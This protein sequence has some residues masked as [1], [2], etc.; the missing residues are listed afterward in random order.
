M[1][2]PVILT[3]IA[4]VDLEKQQRAVDSWIH[5]GFEVRSLNRASE[6]DVLHEAFPAVRFHQAE[7]DAGAVF[8]KPLVYL[9]DLFEVAR[10]EQL[11]VFGIV[12]SDIVFRDKL[13]IREA[14]IDEASRRLVFGSRIDVEHFEQKWGELYW[15]GFDYFFMGQDD[16]ALYPKSDFAIGAPYWDYWVP[17]MPILRNRVP[18]LATDAMAL[19][20]K[21]EQ[22]WDEYQM[23]VT[24]KEIVDLSGIEFE[25]VDHVDMTTDNR[26]ARSFRH[27]FGLFMIEFI[28]RN[29]EKRSLQNVEPSWFRDRDRWLRP[30]HIEPW[31]AG[32]R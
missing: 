32:A 30:G 7:R 17:L 29:S 1:T 3:S 26:S 15:S 31:L 4:P 20:K 11:P 13:P 22:A 5:Q 28:Y 6:I 14:V 18:L 21:H 24:M 27:A 25:G 19:H 12:N 9:D 16:I 8:G 10:A 2:D 23:I